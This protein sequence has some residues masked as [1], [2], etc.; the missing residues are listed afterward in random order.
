[1]SEIFL[2]KIIKICRSSF[3]LRSTMSGMFFETQC[4][5][6]STDTPVGMFAQNDQPTEF[7][8]RK[9]SLNSA[10]ST[11]VAVLSYLLTLV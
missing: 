9:A 1:V 8:G 11:D 2:P 7:D 3:K 6:S 5:Y 10:R 4:I